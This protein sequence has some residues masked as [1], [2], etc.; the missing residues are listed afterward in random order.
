[1]K[2]EQYWRVPYLSMAEI[3]I[4]TQGLKIDEELY[5]SLH[6]AVWIDV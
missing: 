3:W 5:L 6:L 2:C 4:E 1:M